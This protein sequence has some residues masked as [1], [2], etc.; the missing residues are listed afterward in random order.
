MKKVIGLWMVMGVCAG[1]YG[2]E[3]KH[4]PVTVE[5]APEKFDQSNLMG[6]IEK[7]SEKIGD[8]SEVECWVIPIKSVPTEHAMGPWCPASTSDDKSKGGIWLKDGEVYDVDGPFVANLAKLYDDA[9]WN[10]VRED[11]TIKVTDTEEAFMGAA[12]P[13]VDPRYENHCVE[14]P[15][16]VKV[17]ENTVYIIPANPVMN[18]KATRLSRGGI[19]VAFNGVNYDPPA[20]L[21]AIIGAHTIAPLDVHGGHMNPFEGYHY[22][23]ATGSTKEV[24]QDDVHAPMIGY[25]IDGFG[26]YAHLDKEGKEPE[27][28]DECGGHY[29]EVRGYHYHAG[30]PGS[31]Q[32]IKAFRGTP[33]MV[34]RVP[35]EE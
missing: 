5:L 32:I 8:G 14:C 3:S 18:E 10:L 4:N 22:H 29:D 6:E 21:H 25:I 17:S 20:P 19:G 31:N 7:R 28:L 1:V 15:P 9:D 30:S 12:R 24:A 34:M 16:E 23:A 26:L 27:G 13:D 11:G 2:H 33:G 35:D